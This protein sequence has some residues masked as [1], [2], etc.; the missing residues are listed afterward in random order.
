MILY[1]PDDAVS[2]GDN[3]HPVD[4]CD[5]LVPDWLAALGAREAALVACRSVQNPLK[6]ALTTVQNDLAAARALIAGIPSLQTDLQNALA[7]GADF[8]HAV[9]ALTPYLGR[10]KDA[11]RQWMQWLSKLAADV[12]P[13][14]SATVSRDVRYDAIRQFDPTWN[15]SDVYHLLMDDQYTDAADMLAVSVFMSA[16]A[17]MVGWLTVSSGGLLLPVLAQQAPTALVVTGLNLADRPTPYL[18]L[19][20]D[21]V[22]IL[23]NM[24]TL[25]RA[26]VYQRL[27]SLGEDFTQIMIGIRIGP[28]TALMAGIYIATNLPQP[29]YGTIAEMVVKD[30]VFQDNMKGKGVPAI[31]TDKILPVTAGCLNSADAESFFVCAQKAL[32]AAMPDLVQRLRD[33]GLSLTDLR[34]VITAI[35][36]AG[37][38]LRIALDRDRNPGVLESLLALGVAGILE[39]NDYFHVADSAEAFVQKLAHDFGLPSTD[40]IIKKLNKLIQYTHLLAGTYADERDLGLA[41]RLP[42]HDLKAVLADFSASRWDLL[43][44]FAMMKAKGRFDVLARDAAGH[45]VITPN[46]RKLLIAISSDPD[47]RPIAPAFCELFAAANIGTSYCPKGPVP[48]GQ[49]PSSTSSGG[50]VWLVAGAAALAVLSDNKRR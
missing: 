30:P 25:T 31:V 41:L 38:D 13:G 1:V 18:K 2:F 27:V 14:L 21:A 24:N 43:M 49:T 6:T 16:E 8:V 48:E 17:A 23:A 19:L 28:Q 15:Q 32:D 26:D 12:G 4:E 36:K 45:Y 47:L 40:F 37:G 7:T 10:G 39:L 3:A 20:R 22:Y 5:R 34:V 42:D 50:W 11:L 9:D 46:L 35:W 44:G 29:P 33:H